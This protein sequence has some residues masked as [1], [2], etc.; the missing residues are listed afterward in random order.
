MQ[1]DKF[2][3]K[4]QEAV[5]AAQNLAQGKGHQELQPEHLMKILLEQTDGVVAPILQKMGVT[6]SLLQ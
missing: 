1:F 5:Q 4:S 6:P 2:T 3:T